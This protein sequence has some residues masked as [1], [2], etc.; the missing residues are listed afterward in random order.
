MSFWHHRLARFSA[1][2]GKLCCSNREMFCFGRFCHP[3]IVFEMGPF[4]S[5]DSEGESFYCWRA[6]DVAPHLFGSVAKD[7]NSL[8]KPSA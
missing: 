7:I 5:I 3:A 4:V 6:K 1:R 8:Q 2:G